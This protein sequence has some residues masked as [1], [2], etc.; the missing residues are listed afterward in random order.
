[1]PPK[2][3]LK[4]S[5]EAIRKRNYYNQKK[6]DVQRNR[7][8]AALNKLAD[9]NF[10]G[11]K[12][13]M[14]TLLKYHLVKDGKI[15]I[16]TKY[17]TPL[18]DYSNIP[19]VPETS[20]VIN[21]VR[22]QVNSPVS[23]YDPAN[24]KATGAE[25]NNWVYSV[26]VNEPKKSG[27]VR[28]K[29]TIQGCANV[30]KTLAT[31]Y[32]EKYDD[33]ADFLP[34]I[35]NVTKTLELWDKNPA[36]K[37]SASKEK[38]LSYLLKVAQSFPPLVKVVPKAVIDVYDA[39]FKEYRGLAAT[40]QELS[41]APVFEWRIIRNQV[42]NFYGR[43]SY[44][45]LYILLL[46]TIIG[47]DNFGALM[48]DVADTSP[49]EKKKNY[50]I[51]DRTNKK[52]T[53]LLQDFKTV[54]TQ[55]AQ[56]IALDT[57]TVNLII[58]LHPSNGSQ[59]TLFPPN[60]Q[61]NTQKLGAW[62]I[63]QLKKIPLFKDEAI[64]INY[65]RHSLVSSAVARIAMN[66]KD[67]P[68]KL[69]DLANRAM[70]TVGS[71]KKYINDLKDEEG[72]I[73]HIDPETAKDFD[74][75]TTVIEGNDGTVEDGDEVTSKAKPKA[76]ARAPVLPPIAEAAPKVANPKQPAKSKPDQPVRK[77]ARIYGRGKKNKN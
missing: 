24:D 44:E 60:I 74:R 33:K 51:L 31:V 14:K 50:L 68:R 19:K 20:Q 52:A 71:Q 53:F 76:V 9:G 70:H 12:P 63:A 15:E 49:T 55:G 5:A 2:P 54:E 69:L 37:K 39:K 23:S 29:Q 26:L 48:R 6:E 40:E 66:D 42:F 46:N 3:P 22:T 13:S 16:P 64:N 27:E 58:K 73:I 67:R 17:K 11:R 4:Q 77:S 45:A 21:V 57:Q 47:R 8:I 7:I 38:P 59:A 32:G 35:M 62:M 65:L 75:M 56:A 28:S 36:W 10:S 30:A 25:L 61:K 18:I 41:K 34:K 1:M 72:N 43:E